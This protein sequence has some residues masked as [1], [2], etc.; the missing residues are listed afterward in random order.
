MPTVAGTTTEEVLSILEGFYTSLCLSVGRF[1][2]LSEW[3]SHA[4][5]SLIAE[6][7]DDA[8]LFYTWMYSNK[9]G[10]CSFFY[11]PADKT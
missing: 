4:F 1:S 9:N 10:S 2:L 6:A 7:T 8:C 3:L 5:L 11:F